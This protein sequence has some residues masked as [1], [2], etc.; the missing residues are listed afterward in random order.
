MTTERIVEIPWAL[1]QLPQAGRIL[2]VG[3]C[4]ATYLGAVQQP[5]RELHCLDPRPLDPRSSPLPPGAVFH[6]ES[7]IGNHLPRDF[8]DAA[9]VVSTLHHVAPPCY[10]QTPFADVAKI[11]LADGGELLNPCAPASVTLPEAQ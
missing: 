8:F 5:G 1:T 9:L 3:S 7:L 4:D 6:Q 10:A 2:D 11:S